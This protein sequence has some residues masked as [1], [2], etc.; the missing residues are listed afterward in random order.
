MKRRTIMGTAAAALW[1]AA[2]WAH[3]QAP[4]TPV[5]AAT[6]ATKTVYKA[7]GEVAKVD[8]SVREISVKIESGETVVVG[9]HETT[10]CLR[11]APGAKDLAGA[12]AMPCAEIAIGDRIFARGSLGSSQKFPARQIVLMARAD[13]TQKQAREQADWRQRG[14]A[15][16]V[17]AVNVAAQE[18]T[19][20]MRSLLGS[21]EL[22][23]SAAERKASCRRYAP[24]SVRFCDAQPCALADIKVGDQVRALGDRAP[25]GTRFFAEQIVAGSFRTVIGTVAQ[26]RADAREIVLATLP[27][28]GQ[29]KQKLSIAIAPDVTLRRMP[30]EMA[31]RFAM[32]RSGAGM[33]GRF[34]QR[35]MGGG[36]GAATPAQ[37]GAR[38]GGGAPNLG[39]MLD[40]MTAIT[41]ADLK[42]GEYVAIAI[43]EAGANGKTPGAAL[44]AGIEPLITEAPQ[45]GADEM[46]EPSFEG[47]DLGMGM[48]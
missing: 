41:L 10:A 36:A 13:L 37:M 22:T 3:A 38:N 23:I 42:P 24:G 32:Q 19:L 14:I 45:R 25:E 6:A 5:P 46:G 1:I 7:L 21:Q 15:G 29:P 39:E 17:K 35:R 8:A 4:E 12:A 47:L 48:Q 40:R 33:A 31:A 2:Q 30:D 11:A 43:A 18:I 9:F 26:V 16:V 28:R 44:L 20:E 34:G 27:P